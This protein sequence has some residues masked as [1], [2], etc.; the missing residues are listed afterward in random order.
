M[1][2]LENT[3][4]QRLA[5]FDFLKMFAMFM[6]LWGHTIQHLQ[7]GDVWGNSMHKII[8]TFHL[9]ESVK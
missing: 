3:K 5:F 2:K 4:S 8:Y 6:V 9:P 7:T 1:I